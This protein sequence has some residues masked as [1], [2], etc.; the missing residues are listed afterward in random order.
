MLIDIQTY[1][2]W[3][4]SLIDLHSH[5]LPGVDDGAPDLA[6]SLAMARLAVAD[7]V[8][9]LACTPHFYPG[10]YDTSVAQM[11]MAMADLQGELDAASIP[12]RLVPGGDVH[13]APDLV[14]KIRNRIVPTLNGSRYILVEPPHNVLPPRI[15]NIFFDL[16]SAGYQP[17]LT[18]PERMAWIEPKYDLVAQLWRSGVWMQLTAGA[19]TGDFGARARHWSRKIL[20]DGMAHIVASDAHNTH[21]RPPGLSL[22]LRALRD[23]VGSAEAHNLVHTRPA[24]ILRDA[25][26]EEV[27]ILA[28]AYVDPEAP[29]RPKGLLQRL[30]SA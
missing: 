20:R 6:T 18:H 3:G 13:I 15:E 21:A 28:A 30:F 5:I 27:P 19:I 29:A 4:E 12:L 10:V 8:T 11:E 23:L 24:S 14:G 9:A 26:Q 22:A 25:P 2:A 1:L 7:G 17:I 16:L